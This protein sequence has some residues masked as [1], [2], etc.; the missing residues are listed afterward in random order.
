MQRTLDVATSILSTVI[1]LG[2]PRASV[3]YVVRPR[4]LNRVSA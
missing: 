1:R 3:G 4:T 2:S